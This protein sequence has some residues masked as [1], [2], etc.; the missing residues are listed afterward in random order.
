VS[1]ATGQQILYRPRLESTGLQSDSSSRLHGPV[2]LGL[3]EIRSVE[4]P[5]SR[6]ARFALEGFALGASL[7]AVAGFVSIV[8]GHFGGCLG[9]TPCNQGFTLEG[10]AGDVARIAAITAG[11]GALVGALIGASSPEWRRI[12]PVP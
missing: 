2:L 3:A 11:A 10:N 5:H 9:A 8:R 1:M 6:A 12:F 7:G 4:V